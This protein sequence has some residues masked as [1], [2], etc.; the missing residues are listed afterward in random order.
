[1]DRKRRPL[2][3]VAWMDEFQKVNSIK[4]IEIKDNVS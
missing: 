4:S 1:M 3:E 2:N